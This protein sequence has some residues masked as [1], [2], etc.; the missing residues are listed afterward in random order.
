[1]L[2]SKGIIIALGQILRIVLQ[3]RKFGFESS[4]NRN[5]KSMFSN[6]LKIGRDERVRGI[7]TDNGGRRKREDRRQFV[8][9]FHI[10]ERRVGGE[11][12]S[13]EDRRR[14]DRDPEMA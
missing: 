13:G 12:R 8:Y 9:T 7:T 1:M 6:E 2:F 4:Y 5:E 3:P 11:R 14:I 10:P